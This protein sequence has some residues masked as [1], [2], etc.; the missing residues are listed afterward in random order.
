ML[1]HCLK[2]DFWDIDM[3][4]NMILTTLNYKALHESLKENGS[5]EVAKFNWNEPAAKCINV[6]NSVLSE[7]V[8]RK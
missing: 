1:N 3:M 7:Y 4:S 8:R 6:Y 5:R 2:V